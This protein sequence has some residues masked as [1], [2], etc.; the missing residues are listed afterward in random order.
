MLPEQCRGANKK[1][2]VCA[3]VLAV[4]AMGVVFFAVLGV[5]SW[6]ISSG[7][8]TAFSEWVE[9]VGFWGNLVIGAVLALLNVPPLVGY[10]LAIMLCGYLYGFWFGLLTVI[11]G[12]F[13]GWFGCFLA[14][15]KL[16]YH[17]AE[18]VYSPTVLYNATAHVI[19]SIWRKRA[20]LWL[21]R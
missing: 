21:E 8:V 2:A 1:K 9:R 6:A 18:K 16:F 11:I 12:S 15:R 4:L 14:V 17:R 7:K 13:F 20:A 3:G 10:V 5:L 19:L